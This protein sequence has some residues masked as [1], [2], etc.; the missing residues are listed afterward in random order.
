MET[1]AHSMGDQ[2]ASAL[3]QGLRE[4]WREA[5][6]WTVW[7]FG[8]LDLAMLRTAGVDRTFGARLGGWLMHVEAGVRRLILAAALSLTPPAIRPAAIRKAASARKPAAR[9]TAFRI[10]ALRG[11]GASRPAAPRPPQLLRPYAHILFPGD[12]LLRLGA[13]PRIAEPRRFAYRRPN[14]LD[15]W[16]RLSRQDPDWR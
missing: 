9:R 3:P 10:F 13:S 7:L 16:G 4:L 15:R 2:T 8:A 5:C 12:P 6:A 1:D 14:P 11:T